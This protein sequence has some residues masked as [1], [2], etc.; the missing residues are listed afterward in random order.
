MHEYNR[1]HKINGLQFE[2]MYMT[3]PNNSEIL[4]ISY[5]IEDFA[6]DHADK[7]FNS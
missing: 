1:F 7:L 4:E 3:A 5:R 6:L 2:D